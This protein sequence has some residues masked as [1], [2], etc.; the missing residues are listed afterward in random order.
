MYQN[1]VFLQPDFHTKNEMIMNKKTLYT[2]LFCITSI[3]FTN[4]QIVQVGIVKEL[5]SHGKPVAGVGISILTATDLQ[6]VVSNSDGTFRLV[7]SEKKAGD[8]IFNIRIIKEGYEVVNTYDFK[9][10]YTLSSRDTMRIII[11]SKNEIEKVRSRYYNIIYDYQAKEYKKNIDTLKKELDNQ[12]ITI[13][14][15][16][17]KVAKIETELQEANDRI[18]E[19]VNFFARINKDDLDSLSS[20]AL[21]L[22]EQGKFEEAIAIFEQQNLISELKTKVKLRNQTNES[23]HIIIP[24]LQEE[25]NYRMLVMGHENINKVKDI[26]ENIVQSDTSNFQYLFDYALFLSSQK[27]MDEALKWSNRALFHAKTCENK[28]DVLQMIGHLYYQLNDF[29]LSKINLTNAIEEA[30][31]L[32]EIDF[33]KYLTKVCFP[34]NTLANIYLDQNDFTNAERL[35]LVNLEIRRLLVG[36]DSNNIKNYAIGLNNIAEL[37][38]KIYDIN[39]DSL[40]FI[41]AINYY[42]EAILIR[43]STNKINVFDNKSSLSTLY[44]NKGT[45]FLSAK[46]LDSANYYFQKSYQILQYLIS[47]NPKKY[48][49]DIIYCIINLGVLN[50]NLKQYQDAQDYYAQGLTYCNQSLHENPQLFS[51]LKAKILCNQGVLYRKMKQNDNAR[52][53][54]LEAIE[55]YQNIEPN[56]S[57]ALAEAYNN[58][59]VLHYSQSQFDTAATYMKNA[60]DLIECLMKKS[61]DTYKFKYA[62]Y[63]YNIGYFYFKANDKKNAIPEYKKAK[64]LFEKLENQYPDKCKT[65]LKDIEEESSQLKKIKKTKEKK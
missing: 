61:P 46:I 8:Q 30:E 41:K 3:V 48:E 24:K 37:Y 20:N 35:L 44:N 29:N 39:K 12:T 56:C 21:V 51:I 50:S 26:L 13:E 32:K 22:L 62:V 55:I 38:R 40:V 23:I 10:G 16:R 25:V 27:N 15:Y 49:E 57:A 43:T 33:D 2:F 31:K 58:L 14:E 36:K 4:A 5:N 42:D 7:F 34:I 19:Y 53:S 60:R 9:N 17:N 64:K 1:I 11:A 54:Y 59:S 63:T 52:L 45:L 18:E 65:Y 6:P 28:S 47:V